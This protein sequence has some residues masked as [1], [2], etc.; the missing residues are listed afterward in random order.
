MKNEKK[1]YFMAVTI[2][3]KISVPAIPFLITHTA[4]PGQK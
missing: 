2:D 4:K 3:I 1:F